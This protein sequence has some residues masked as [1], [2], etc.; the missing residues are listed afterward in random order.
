MPS[1]LA[2]FREGLG[3]SRSLL[4]LERAHFPNPP[5][6]D[7]QAAVTALRSGAIV[8][9]VAA[10]ERFIRDCVSEHLIAAFAPPMRYD[11]SRLPDAV[12]KHHYVETMLDGIKG[13]RYAAK[14]STE[15]ALA[16]RLARASKM[17][18]TD[19]LSTRKCLRS[20]TQIPVAKPLSAC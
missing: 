7:Q 16:A 14:V 18:M 13:P 20:R 2:D 15:R 3:R 11:L 10:F 1:A 17:L 5:L 8:L 12:R 19:S 9:M 4:E 6:L